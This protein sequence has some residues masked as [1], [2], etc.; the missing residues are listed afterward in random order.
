MNDSPDTYQTPAGEPAELEIVSGPYDG[1]IIVIERS[2]CVIG[3]NTED[4]TLALDWD[5][6]VSHRHAEIRWRDGQWWICD[7]GSANGI[8]IGDKTLIRNQE[9]SLPYE[10]VIG[11][12]H[13]DLILR[14]HENE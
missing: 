5:R 7:L 3:R 6:Q 2:P 14:Q 10:T 8:E 1:K 4:L 12:G 9:A 13:T 11:I